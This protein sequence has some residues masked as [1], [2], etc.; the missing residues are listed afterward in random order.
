MT[1]ADPI[2][3]PNP[4]ATP[5]KSGLQT[6]E[7]YV[8][9]LV[10]GGLGWAIQS[11]IGMIPTIAQTPGMPPWAAPLMSLAPIALGYVAKLVASEYAS[12]RTQLKLGVDTSAQAA[13]VAAEAA[14]AKVLGA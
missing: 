4:T 10:L 14:P 11:L 1:M 7:L 8:C 2:T 5:V 13:G 9:V 6:T 3:Q 12:L